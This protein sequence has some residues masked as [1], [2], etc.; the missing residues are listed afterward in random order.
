M[1]SS[2]AILSSMLVLD[3]VVR[4][5]HAAQD[6]VKG[7][8]GGG[9]I[10]GRGNIVINLTIT[11]FYL[12]PVVCLDE[13]RTVQD[14]GAAH[15]GAHH[16]HAVLLGGGLGEEVPERVEGE[17]VA[18]V[19]EHPAHGPVLVMVQVQRLQHGGAC[20]L[21][22]GGRAGHSAGDDNHHAG[23]CVAGEL[24]GLVAGAPEVLGG[25]EDGEE[26]ED[27]QD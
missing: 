1:W 7:E 2:C 9:H 3:G 11:I 19:G 26:E 17:G 8:E 27:T 21:A 23:D 13:G 6:L 18:A 12:T 25:D 24:H 4:L 10:A 22:P 20:R 16:G 14:G 15:L 5:V